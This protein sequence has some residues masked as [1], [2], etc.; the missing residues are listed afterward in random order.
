MFN[1][2]SVI[3]DVREGKEIALVL[4]IRKM[5]LCAIRGT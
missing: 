1:I 4:R 5:C 3:P 2:V